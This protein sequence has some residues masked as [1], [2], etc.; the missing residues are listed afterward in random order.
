M[1]VVFN[2]CIYIFCAIFD[3][4][5]GGRSVTLSVS[6]Y[7]KFSAVFVMFTVIIV[8][9]FLFVRV[10]YFVFF[11]FVFCAIFDFYFVRRSFT[12]SAWRC[13]K[14]SAAVAKFEP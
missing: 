3:L 13:A 1:S 2:F 6:R 9:L 5:F 11:A 10:L 4:Y 8:F 12:L 7:A 14:S